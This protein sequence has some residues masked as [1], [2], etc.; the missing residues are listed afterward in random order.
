MKKSHGVVIVAAGWRIH[1][2]G[3][4]RSHGAALLESGDWELFPN[5]E[6]AKEAGYE[7]CY[8]CFPDGRA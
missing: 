7:P 2:P 3:S 4:G 8:S 6:T 1:Q 5:L